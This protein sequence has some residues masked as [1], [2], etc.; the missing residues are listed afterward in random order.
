[1]LGAKHTEGSMAAKKVSIKNLAVDMDIKNK[2][3]ELDVYDGD[4]HLGDLY[5]TKTGLVWCKGKTT[6]AN[7]VKIKWRVF[8]DWAES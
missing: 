6:K 2:G 8:R 3:V 1:M 4:T 5:V 7:G